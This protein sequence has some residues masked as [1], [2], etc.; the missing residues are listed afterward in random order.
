MS[1]TIVH[2]TTDTLPRVVTAVGSPALDLLLPFRVDVDPDVRVVSWQLDVEV[3]GRSWTSRARTRRLRDGMAAALRDRMARTGAFSFEHLPAYAALHDD[4]IRAGRA[5]YLEGRVPRLRPGAAVTYALSVTLRRGGEDPFVVTSPSWTTHAVDP[6]FTRDDVRRISIPGAFHAS[7]AWVLYH[8]RAFGL[9]QVR[10]DVADLGADGAPERADLTVHVGDTAVELGAARYPTLPLVDVAADS[11][12]F[13]VP[14]QG[15][16]LPSVTVRYRTGEPVPVD[17]NDRVDVGEARVVFVNFAIQGLND[18]FATPD[19]DYD[20]PRTYTQLTMRDEAASYSSRPGSEENTVGDGYAFTI[21]AHRRFRVPQ[22]WAMNG[23]LA[24]LLAHDRPDDLAAMRRDVEAGL[25]VPVV[26]GYGAHRLPFYTGET[27]LDA[28]RFGSEVLRTVLG[29]VRPVY[30]PDQRLTT[31]RPEV[32]GALREAGVEYLVVDAGTGQGAVPD[33]ATATSGNTVV[34][35]AKPPMGAFTDGRW[36]NWQYLWRDR[37]SGAKVLFIDREMKDGLFAADGDTA[38]R[39]KPA[40]GLRCK[41][42]EMAAAPVRHERNLLVY[43]D[44]A[45]KASGNGW[46]DGGYDA[47]AANNFRYQAVLSWLAAHPWVRVVTT[48]DLD[49]DDVVGELDLLRASDPF[50]EEEWRLDHV[51]PVADHDYGLAYDTWYAAWARTPAAWLGEPLRAISD[52]AEEAIARRRGCGADDELVLLARLYFTMCLH[53]SQWSKR[54]RITPPKEGFDEVENF[55]AAETLQLRNA[56]VFLAASFWA[57]WAADVTTGTEEPGA[58]RDGGRVVDAVAAFEQAGFSGGWPA[59]WRPEC[60]GLQWDHD[61]LPN[62]VL[63]NETALVVVDRNG[64]RVTHLFAM[65]DGRPVSVSGTH[66]A[67]QFVEA[68]WSS[69]GGVEC[70]GLVLQNTVWSPN[71]AHVACDVEASRGTMGSRPPNDTGFNMYYPDN[72]N[73]YD[74]VPEGSSAEG[75]STEGS[76][77]EGSSTEDGDDALPSVTL[78]YGPG[79]TDEAPPDTVAALAAVLEAD[80]VEKVAGRRGTVHHDVD[81]FG[82]FRKTIRLDGRTVHVEYRDTAP[83]HRVANEFCVDLLA[84]ALHGRRQAHDVAADGRSATVTNEDGLTVRLELGDGCT[85]S[86]AACAPLHPPS[87]DSLRLHRVMTDDLEIVAPDG[88]DFAYRIVLP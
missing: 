33:G 6:R 67:Y 73:A 65:V 52:R 37:R 24:G 22:M 18:L 85:F 12:T 20:P 82:S 49:D 39:G 26:A 43:S 55:V 86:D 36:M 79:S 51:P 76:S 4:D 25:L 28:I 53:E 80:R 15:D 84:A 74:E 35:D 64:G 2:V 38:D 3:E 1:A 16:A 10:I 21:D 54:P 72:F 81:E 83:G 17:L 8:R 88:G 45:D 44:D 61:P 30:Y 59:W 7:E 75:S 40:H 23:G 14:H 57:Q 42:L 87:V 63:Y 58:Y 32:A 77:T 69:D 27:N 19:D 13:A 48:D 71:H 62:V 70:D 5:V 50:I 66:K 60:A 68:D 78:R 31:S 41:F 47:R 34:A 9:D 29:A 56:H 11:V 46:F